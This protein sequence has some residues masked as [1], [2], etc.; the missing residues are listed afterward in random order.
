MLCVTIR[1]VYSPRNFQISSST[2]S[3]P[4]GVQRRTRFVH[5]ENLRLDRQ[6]PRDAQLLLLLQR[7]PRRGLVQPV[8]HGVPQEDLAQRRFQHLVLLRR[9]HL[10]QPRLVQ[11]EAEEDVVAYRDRQRIGTLE[12]HADLLADLYQLDI[13][14][15]DVVAQHVDVPGR[16]HVSQPFDDAVAGTQQG[17]LPAP[18]GAD[19][20][21]DHAALHPQVDVEERLEVA[22]PEVQASRDSESPPTRRQCPG[23]PAPRSSEASPRRRPVVRLILGAALEHRPPFRSTSTSSPVRK[24]AVPSR[25]AARLLDEIRDQHDRHLGA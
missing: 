25:Q 7:Q 17:G 16:A 10:A 14:A 13:V 5:Q 20:R 19:H 2:A 24:K 23:S 12:D 6:Q 3:V 21:G 11:F 22:V 1:I 8:L 4:A 18:G 9:A 15:E